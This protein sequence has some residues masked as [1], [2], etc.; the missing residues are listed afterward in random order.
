LHLFRIKSSRD[1]PEQQ[2][3]RI[4]PK[5]AFALCQV[6]ARLPVRLPKELLQMIVKLAKWG[7]TLE[8]VSV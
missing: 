5:T 4:G 6:N 2:W 7:F 8:E 1:I 3:Q